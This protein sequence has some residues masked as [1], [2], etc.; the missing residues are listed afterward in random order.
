MGRNLQCAIHGVPTR[1]SGSESPL[2][3]PDR[4]PYSA[5]SF[6]THPRLR[7]TDEITRAITQSVETYGIALGDA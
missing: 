2:R 7:S 3:L 6:A 4:E 5:T 1:E